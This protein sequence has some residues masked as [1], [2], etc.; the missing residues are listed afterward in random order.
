MTR[1]IG[2]PLTSGYPASPNCAPELPT[3]NAPASS[4]FGHTPRY[5][6]AL[7][8]VAKPRRIPRFSGLYRQLGPALR[9]WAIFCIAD[10][11][12]AVAP[13][14]HLGWHKS[15]IFGPRQAER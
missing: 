7:G 13:R 2:L 10:Y 15:D 1:P 5:W 6:V 9:A 3:R 4:V 8:W 11:W 14:L 12:D